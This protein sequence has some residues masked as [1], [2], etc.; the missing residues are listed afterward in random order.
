MQN[1]Q[2]L[3]ELENTGKYVFHGSPYGDIKILEPKQ[4]THIPDTSKP[5]ETILDGNPAVSATPYI[6]FAIFRAI[7]N[8]KNIKV[9][10]HSGFGFR[11][12]V[13]EFRVSDKLILDQLKDKKGFVYVFNR[14]DFKPY[15]RDGVPH[16]G[17][18]E[19]R[20]YESVEPIEVI[21]VSDLDLISID[22][23]EIM[24]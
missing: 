3:L 18:M 24:K 19:W 11:N 20:S 7:I 8:D 21:K 4:G 2:K 15:S 12:G 5:T 13:K 14:S 22:L 1:K 17:N 10:F 9:K 6:D 16:E 23:I